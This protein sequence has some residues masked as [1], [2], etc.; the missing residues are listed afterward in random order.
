M[1]RHLVAAV[2]LAL[3]VGAAS[4]ALA[5]PVHPDHPA[6]PAKPAKGRPARGIRVNGGGVTA[7]GVDFS[8]QA[9]NGKS[10]GHFNYT[11]ADGTLTV[12]CQGV[13]IDPASAAGT[14]HV[15]STNCVTVASDGTRTPITPFDATFFDNGKGQADAANITVGSVT[16]NGT[17]QS[18]SIHVR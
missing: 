5:K 2:C 6:H 7:A 12:N 4:P 13:S 1:R 18:G 16:D 15:T 14:A 10:K 11:K 17:L 3:L 9:G 8:V